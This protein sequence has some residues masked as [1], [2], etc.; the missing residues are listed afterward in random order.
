[1]TTNSESSEHSFPFCTS[2]PVLKGLARLAAKAESTPADSGHLIEFRSM[3]VRGASSTDQSPSDRLSLAYSI[4]P[5]RGCEFGCRY[6]YA[7]YTHD[8][9]YA[10]AAGVST[11]AT[12][13]DGGELPGATDLSQPDAFERIIFLKKNAAWLLEQELRKIDPAE[14]IALGTA[15]DPYQPIERRAMSHAEF[16]GSVCA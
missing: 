8:V 2:R 16:A 11:G 4:N 5:Y 12:E 6:C 13:G 14:E 3:E 15:T 9:S 10:A 7:R 1:M